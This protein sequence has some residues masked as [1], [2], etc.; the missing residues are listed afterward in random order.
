MTEGNRFGPLVNIQ[1]APRAVEEHIKFWIDTYLN[2]VE[3]D[4]GL[5]LHT[6]ARPA[7]YRKVNLLQ[8]IPSEDM[9]P[10]VIII[11]RGDAEAP[12]RDGKTYTLPLDLGV[13]IATSSFEGDGAREVAGAYGAAVF[14]LMMHKRNLDGRMDDKLRVVSWDGVRLDDLAGVG[15]EFR[16]RAI[17]R[18]EFTLQITGV[19][20]S[21]SGPLIPD[22]PVDP[23]PSTPWPTVNVGQATTTIDKRSIEEDL[24]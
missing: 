7:S 18:L 15:E 1:S 23:D 3:E 12:R 4:S 2:G 13:A 20:W 6:Y 24:T 11:T 21:T 14:G 5:D 22:V 17:I 8:G 10:T 16:T 19:L 9:S